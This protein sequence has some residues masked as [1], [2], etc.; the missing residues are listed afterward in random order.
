M[1]AVQ[2]RA[3]VEKLLK[4]PTGIDNEA[5]CLGIAVTFGNE[6]RGMHDERIKDAE[7]PHAPEC[8]IVHRGGHSVVAV[9][10][11]K[12]LARL[13]PRFFQRSDQQNEQISR[14]A[15]KHTNHPLLPESVAVL[16]PAMQPPVVPECSEKRII[17]PAK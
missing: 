3:P 2:V 14:I 4:T 12:R 5:A 15:C 7:Q 6:T 1:P 9:Q 11:I 16:E 17:G 10:T 8:V 13:W